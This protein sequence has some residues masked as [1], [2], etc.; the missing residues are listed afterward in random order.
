MQP[1]V[2]EIS[3]G[4]SIVLNSLRFCS[5][6]FCEECASFGLLRYPASGIASGSPVIR[7]G[8]DA[9]RGDHLLQAD[10]RGL[11]PPWEPDSFRLADEPLTM[12]RNRR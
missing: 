2:Q 7:P 4:C 1:G 9:K 8:I 10:F 6:G 5:V 11:I 12:R 3:P